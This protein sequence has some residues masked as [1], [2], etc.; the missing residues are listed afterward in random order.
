MAKVTSKLQLTIP[1]AIA[2][3]YGIRPGDRIELVPAGETIRMIPSKRPKPVSAQ[4]RLRIFDGI[5]KRVDVL[6]ARHNGESTQQPES[7]GWTREYLYDR[8]GISR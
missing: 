4:E 8:R 7:R 5:M 2:S 1:K 3:Q 6:A